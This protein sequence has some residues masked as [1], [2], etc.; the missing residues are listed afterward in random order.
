MHSCYVYSTAVH[1]HNTT[2]LMFAGKG[3]NQYRSSL[4]KK[5]ENVHCC[6]IFGVGDSFIT[7]HIIH[8]I[9]LFSPNISIYCYSFL[10]L[11]L[12][13]VEWINHTHNLPGKKEVAIFNIFV[14]LC[15]STAPLTDKPPKIL[16]PS[17]RQMS[18]IELAIGK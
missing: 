18:I 16:S 17:E 3:Q 15:H 2:M 1:V 13:H 8:P 9:L 6:L 11:P 4:L 14:S 5:K 10:V 7:H 12:F